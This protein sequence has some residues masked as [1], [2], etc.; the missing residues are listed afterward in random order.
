MDSVV[1]LVSLGPL[2]TE[3]ATGAGE[4]DLM[5]SCEMPVAE[6]NVEAVGNT[7]F[8]FRNYKKVEERRY[9]KSQ[10]QRVRY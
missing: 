9:E 7:R 2:D 3:Q 8:V 4:F 6:S 10:S 5:S 1:V